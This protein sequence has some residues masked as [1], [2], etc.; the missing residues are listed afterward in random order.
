V[1]LR[2]HGA[3]RRALRSDDVVFFLHSASVYLVHCQ[4]RS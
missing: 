1:V 3:A 4:E 2:T